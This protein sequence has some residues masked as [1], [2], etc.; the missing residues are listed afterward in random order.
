MEPVFDQLDGV[1]ATIPG[2]TGGHKKD[3]TYQEVCAGGTGHTEALQ[4]LFD[5]VKISYAELLD[6]FWKNI[7]PA[8]ADGQFVDRG[9]QYRP[10]VFFHDEEQ[11]RLA[12]DSR[13]RLAKSGIFESPIRVEISPAGDFYPAEEYHQNFY[14][15]SPLR[16]KSYR[17]NSGRDQFLQKIWGEDK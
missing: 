13:E 14:Q 17:Y 7:N 4:I 10:A 15:K 6:V 9:S 8:D 1:V 12:E 3:P 2:Y 16:Y 5:P 11:Q